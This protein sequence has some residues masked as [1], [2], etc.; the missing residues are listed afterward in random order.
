MKDYGVFGKTPSPDIIGERLL[1]LAT[2]MDSLEGQI[3]NLSLEV[4][5]IRSL[6]GPFG[7]AFRQ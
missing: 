6:V 5:N 7:V 4:Q 1:G 3:A 2:K